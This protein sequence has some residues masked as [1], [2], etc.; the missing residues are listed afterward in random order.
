MARSG[1]PC[2][3]SC[4]L[5]VL[6]LASNGAPSKHPPTRKG[7]Q[8]RTAGVLAIKRDIGISGGFNIRD[9]GLKVSCRLEE[10]RLLQKTHEMTSSSFS[11]TKVRS[12]SN[13][14]LVPSSVIVSS[15]APRSLAAT[16]SGGVV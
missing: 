8:H 15:P 13:S 11:S 9:D 16:G 2:P 7:W 10:M 14:E 5:G 12:T 3:I 6:G 1:V 4:H